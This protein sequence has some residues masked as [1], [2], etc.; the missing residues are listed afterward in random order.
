MRNAV[1]I[2]VALA[3]TALIA[4]EDHDQLPGQSQ[5]EPLAWARVAKSDSAAL[6]SV[7]G[8]SASDVCIAGADDGQ[9]PAILHFDGQGW[10]RR[11]SGVKGDLWWVNATPQGPVYFAGAS[12]MLVRY[13]DGVF[14]R[15]KTPGLGKDV[16]YGV[17][18]AGADDLYAVGT[19]AG[20]NGFV[21]HYDGAEFR[22]LALPDALPSGQ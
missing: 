6:L 1:S 18:A 20:R 5:R 17:W 2:F 12:A 15:L 21:W 9:G 14:T 22:S 4:C 10:Q 11:N 7:S 13:Q 19:S 8:T 16:L 3:G